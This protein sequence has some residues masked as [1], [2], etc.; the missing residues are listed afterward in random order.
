MPSIELTGDG[1]TR[2]T[3]GDDGSSDAHGEPVDDRNP[4]KREGES[5]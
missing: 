3:V 2:G 5:T 1:M 4:A